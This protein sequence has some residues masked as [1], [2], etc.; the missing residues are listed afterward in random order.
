MVYFCQNTS[1]NPFSTPEQDC[2]QGVAFGIRV[3]CAVGGAVIGLVLAIIIRRYLRRKRMLSAAQLQ[4][5]IPMAH[6]NNQPATYHVQGFDTQA[7]S[8]AQPYGPPTG[9]PPASISNEQLV[10]YVPPLGPPPPAYHVPTK[11]EN[12]SSKEDEAT[13]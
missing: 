10:L 4:P 7:N 12:K 9:T 2:N 11:G 6:P 1:G 3:G 13:A 5:V 8:N